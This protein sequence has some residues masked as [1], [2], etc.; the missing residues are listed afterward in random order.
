MSD[1]AAAA[2]SMGIPESL[3]QRSAEAKAE[4]TGATVE[5][6]LAAWAA[7]ETE[8][9]GAA[10]EPAGAEPAASEEPATASEVDAPPEPAATEPET[11]A[12]PPVPISTEP[13]KPP[14]LV[15]SS[16]NPLS[17][18]V[19]AIGLFL[20]IFLVGLV[21]PSIQ[22]EEPGARSSEVDLSE[23]G[24]DGLALYTSL[25]CAACHTQMVRPVVADVGLGA[26]TLNDSNQPLGTRRYGPDLSDIGSRMS[27]S[28]ME[29]VITGFDS[30]PSLNLSSD[31]MNALVAYLLESNTSGAG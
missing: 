8:P 5:E 24:E 14:V 27:G 22:A 4:E 12:A 26:V 31:E 19:G 25:G 3:V 18:M 2:A 21:G 29:A 10:A 6:I 20:L 23:A 13:A 15:G 30:H 16:D 28:Q 7:G 1:L 17:I 9:S 11:P